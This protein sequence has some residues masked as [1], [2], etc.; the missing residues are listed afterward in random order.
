MKRK[1]Y[2]IWYENVKDTIEINLIREFFLIFNKFF[3][4]VVPMAEN[5]N[6]PV[7]KKIHSQ[8][9]CVQQLK[10]SRNS[11]VFAIFQRQRRLVMI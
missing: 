7:S 11:S 6:S 4:Y 1:A 2:K 9:F 5:L 10:F 8:K 3:Y